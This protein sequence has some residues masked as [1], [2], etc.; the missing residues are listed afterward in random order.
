M[1]LL[2]TIMRMENL[3]L[4]LN[5]SDY[6]ESPE[7]T[8]GCLPEHILQCLWTKEEKPLCISQ[9][10]NGLDCPERPDSKNEWVFEW[11]LLWQAC[12]DRITHSVEQIGPWVP[13]GP[14]GLSTAPRL[15]LFTE[16]GFSQCVCTLTNTDCVCNG[17]NVNAAILLAH[18]SA[19]GYEKKKKR[20]WACMCARWMWNFKQ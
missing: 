8:Y 4:P 13:D 12:C 15:R 10:V 19:H 14:R 18:C 3:C 6:L 1:C 9:H 16:M 7:V 17:P 20:I 5:K 2:L 11:L